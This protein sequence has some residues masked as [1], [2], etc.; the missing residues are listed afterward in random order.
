MGL[1]RRPDSPIWWINF[2][3]HGKVYRKSTGTSEK[4]LAEKIYAKVQTQV[5]EGKWFEFDGAR[6]H[7]FDEMMEK[8]MRE[9]SSIHKAKSSY[10]KDKSLLEHLNLSFSGLSLYQIAPRTISD[11]KTGRLIQ[12][13]SPASVRNELRLLSHAFN[14]ALKQWEW[15]KDNPVSKVSFK[16]LKA[17]TIDRWLTLEEEKKL[18]S[19]VSGK[20]NGHLGDIVIVALNTGMSQEEILNLT[21]QQ[22]DLFRRTL[23][24]TRQKTK[25]TRTIPLNETIVSLLKQKMKVRPI[26]GGDHV[27]FNGAGNRID[28]GKLKSKFIRSVKESGIKHFR[29]HDLRHTFATR[30]VQRG[31]D[32]YKVAKLLGHKDITTTQRYAHHYPES[33]RDGVEILDNLTAYEKG[34]FH[35]FVTLGG[36]QGDN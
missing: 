28:A 11:Y 2:T 10:G 18:L 29:F 8:Y 22:I 33:L 4:K 26:N 5:I 34:H 23:I 24:T 14:I 20:L 13:S 17:R 6:Q 9:Y 32:L 1:Y 35:D 19:A 25:S 3:A 36:T 31:V 21:W 15:I 16:E 27:F 30:L 12:G 7:T